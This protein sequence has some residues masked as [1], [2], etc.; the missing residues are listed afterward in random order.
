MSTQ[1]DDDSL[2]RRLYQSRVE[3]LLLAELEPDEVMLDSC[4]AQLTAPGTLL[5]TDRRLIFV[6]K[7]VALRRRPR[8]VLIPRS[9]VVSIDVFPGR[10]DTELHIATTQGTFRFF[11]VDSAEALRLAT[12]HATHPIASTRG[13]MTVD[14]PGPRVKLAPVLVVAAGAA[15]AAWWPLIGFGVIAIGV[16]YIFLR[17]EHAGRVPRR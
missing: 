17:R 16:V 8:R 4:F 12:A 11:S 5:L 3:Q 7:G 6:G 15:I 1:R 9:E 13:T 14:D 2:S 10:F